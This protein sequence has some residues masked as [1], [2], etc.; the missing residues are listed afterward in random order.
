MDRDSVLSIF[1]SSQGDEIPSPKMMSNWA[2]RKS[3]VKKIVFSFIASILCG[4]IM[5]DLDISERR[6]PQDGKIKFKKFGPLDIELRVATIPT[7]GGE[8][9]VVLRI[10]QAGEPI[11]LAKRPTPPVIADRV[12]LGRKDALAYVEDIYRGPGLAGVPP[13]AGVGCKRSHSSRNGAGGLGIS[14]K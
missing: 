1:S 12:D 4:K 9:D 14:S 5:A 7:V 8:E 11:P 10:L 3:G 13:V 2:S 6:K